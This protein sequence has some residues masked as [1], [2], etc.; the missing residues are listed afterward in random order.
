MSRINV[1][2]GLQFAADNALGC[3]I[4]RHHGS[5]ATI[6]DVHIITAAR[7]ARVSMLLIESSHF[8]VLPDCIFIGSIIAQINRVFEVLDPGVDRIKSRLPRLQL[9]QASL[10]TKPA[11]NNFKSSENWRAALVS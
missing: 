1:V 3:R 8:I 2:C 5:R 4:F 7:M 6:P 9:Y 10:M 11:R